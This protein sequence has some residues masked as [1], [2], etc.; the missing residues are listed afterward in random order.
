MG[1]PLVA[2]V[3]EKLGP[4]VNELYISCNRNEEE[5]A[6]FAASLIADTRDNFQGP[7]AGIETSARIIDAGYLIVVACD[8]PKL[9]RDLVE[10][11][12]RPLLSK[13]KDSPVISYAN[14]GQYNQYLFA[15]L[16]HSTLDSLSGFLE[17]GGRAVRHWYKLHRSVAVD[18]SDQADAFVNYNESHL[19]D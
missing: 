19:F 8:T 13:R 6:R 16:H 10:R 12:L 4:Q 14:D 11:L 3:A 2:H 15:A 18:F 17:D 9:P 5:Y 1:K 7:L